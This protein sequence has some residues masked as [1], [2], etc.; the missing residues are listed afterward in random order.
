MAELP[1]DIAVVEEHVAIGPVRLRLTRPR[2]AEELIDESEFDADE[3]L[4][5]W[6]DIWPSGRVLAELL[7]FRDL[8]GVRAVELGA[9]L[10]LP[11]L[12][13]ARRGAQVV[14]TDW[15]EPALAFVHANAERAG[16]A[17]ET[18]LA[19]WRS[20]PR[21]LLDAAPFDLVI[22]ADVLYEAR[23]VEPLA[24]LLPRLTG[25][26]SQVIIADPRRPNARELL[27]RLSAAG[28]AAS[29]DEF[30]YRGRRDESGPIVR[31]HTLRPP[32]VTP[33]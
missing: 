18:M 2:S 17:V 3:R 24:A 11:S 12:I 6:A 32:A 15:Y 5:Y 23:H 21:A 19:D 4:P 30:A 27:N 31:V 33:R 16:L 8:A 22:A 29:V 26:R 14:A 28:W 13:A 20:P 25:P 7:A 1:P 9:G 10:A